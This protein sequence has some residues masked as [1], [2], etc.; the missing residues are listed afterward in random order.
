[1]ATRK[2]AAKATAPKAVTAAYLEIYALKNDP[3]F[4]NRVGMSLINYATYLLGA[5]PARPWHEYEI[6]WSRK[7]STNTDDQIYR[8]MGFVLGDSKVQEQL[9]DIPDAELQIVVEVAVQKNM[10]VLL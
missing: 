7:A 9:A 4:R 2:P 3:D 6:N 1:M 10:A 5:D 8:V